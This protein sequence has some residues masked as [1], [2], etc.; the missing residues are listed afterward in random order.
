M[1]RNAHL[2]KRLLIKVIWYYIGGEKETQGKFCW[3][4]VG[5]YDEMAGLLWRFWRMSGAVRM[6][7]AFGRVRR[8]TAP[9]GLGRVDNHGKCG[10]SER[11][12]EKK[13]EAMFLRGFKVQGF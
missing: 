4:A 3:K 1:P 8:K 13:P 6:Q 10:W 11:R 5:R 7:I 12:G 9:T 2:I